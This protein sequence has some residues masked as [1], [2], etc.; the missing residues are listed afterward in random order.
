MNIQ[1]I[2]EANDATIIEDKDGN[3]AILAR[4]YDADGIA[5]VR[6][7]PDRC[8]FHSVAKW[9]SMTPEQAAAAVC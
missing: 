7:Y 5:V 4:H 1:Q 2:A 9:E 6:Y 8:D 3:I